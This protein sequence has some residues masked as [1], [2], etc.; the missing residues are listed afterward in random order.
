MRFANRSYWALCTLYCVCAIFVVRAADDALP[1]DIQPALQADLSSDGMLTWWLISPQIESAPD[2][3]PPSNAREGEPVFPGNAAL[4]GA[5][6]PSIAGT[7]YNDLRSHVTAPKGSLF[8]ATRLNSSAGGQRIF[9]LRTYCAV[10]VFL[11]GKLLLTKPQP[12]GMSVFKVPLTLPKGLSELVVEIVPRGENCVMQCLVHDGRGNNPPQKPVPG[13][14]IVLPTAKGKTPDADA[15]AFKC[16]MVE[17]KA[18]FITPGGKAIIMAG[19]QGSLPRGTNSL[20]ARLISPAQKEAPITIGQLFQ[21]E[22]VAP[23]ESRGVYEAQL[24]FLANGKPIGVKTVSLIC[25]EG[26]T[27]DAAVLEKDWRERSVK[28]GHSMPNTK[29]AIEKIKL[30]VD[31]IRTGTVDA[32]GEVAKE[33]GELIENAHRFAE[34]EEQ[35]KDPFE[36]KSGY[37]VRGYTSAIDD[38]VQPYIVSVPAAATAKNADTFPLIVFLHGYDPNMNKHRWWEAKDYAAVCARNGC[39]LAI[40][41][42]RLN[43]DFQ[44]CGEVDVLDVIKEMKAHYRIDPDRVYLCGISMGGMGVYSLAAHYPD[45]FAAAMVLAGRADSPLQNNTAL[46]NFHPFKQWLIN[47]DNPISLCENLTNIPLRIYHGQD[48]A[49]VPPTQALR[50]S[51]ALKKAGCDAKLLLVPGGHRSGF[52]ILRED[53]P[54][55]WLL[56][57]KRNNKPAARHLK[58]YSLQYVSDDYY[59]ATTNALEPIDIEWKGQGKG[60]VE[61]LKKSG[62]VLAFDAAVSFTGDGLKTTKSP[63]LC[64]P[65]RQAMCGPFTIVYGTK[66]TP[67]ANEFNKKNAERF[68]DEW[69]LFTR[70]RAKI[71]ADT[72]VTPE[73]K[74]DRN[75]FL[76]GEEQ[77]N[78]LHAE[79][80]KDL[81]ISIKDGNVTL[82]GKTVPL[83][84][85]GIRYIFPSTFS[86]GKHAV[87]ICA[88]IPYGEKIGVNHKLDLIPDFLLYDSTFDTDGTSTNHAL[89]AGF[90]DNAWKLDEKLTWWFDKK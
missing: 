70:S 48:D 74:R 22:Y 29:L 50:M 39:F 44:T 78:A 5:W 83:A 62:N 17:S 11:D 30:F 13:D 25:L 51:A 59:V 68:A 60:N 31:G 63:H 36:G 8:A 81:P 87:V 45:Q 35:G 76:F 58:T 79:L 57:N 26:F 9:Y 86:G 47:V 15:A 34:L 61:I 72:D 69:L 43:T 80:A 27:Q 6:A 28:S 41:F 67:A 21:T 90:F 12:E 73:E 77:D 32:D 19:I 20:S 18:P 3:K 75:L 4:P 16:F 84:G 24:E 14:S 23:A 38:G 49:V 2:A 88:G 7:F 66:G 37:M 33:I 71:K 1:A 56:S 10:I 65:V 52:D 54:V 89:C 64:G 82:A 85:K 55:R 53:E 46:E 40:P 42:G